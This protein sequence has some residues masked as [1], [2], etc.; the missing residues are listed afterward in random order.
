MSLPPD[1]NNTT[2]FYYFIGR[3]N[4]PH[5]G[6]IAALKKLVKTANEK[7]STPLILLGSG[8]KGER[9]LDNPITYDLKSRFIRANLPGDYILQEMKSPASDVSQYIKT[10]LQNKNSPAKNIHI[11]HM[12][13]DKAEDATKLNFIKP[14][15]YQT[16]KNIATKAE[17][18][19]NTEAL[20]PVKMNGKE[21]SATQVRKDAYRCFLE[22]E[23]GE[24]AFKQ[25]YGDFYKYFTSEMYE[26]IVEPARQLSEEQILEYIETGKMTNTKTRK[27]KSPASPKSKSKPR[28][29]KKRG[30]RRSQRRRKR[31]T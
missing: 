14:V 12:A 3:L 13:G 21:M 11:T 8:P 15:A 23:S 1:L 9:T 28:T 26:Q 20:S 29:T 2:Y 4:P 10:A 31:R 18:T 25:K 6:H 27:R 24:E 30:G 22:G 17:V 19:T 16:A 5:A 7:K